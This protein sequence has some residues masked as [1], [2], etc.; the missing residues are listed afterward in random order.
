ML[1]SKQKTIF[2]FI[3]QGQM[4]KL[5]GDSKK[6]WT[7]CK[8]KLIRHQLLICNSKWNILL[9][10]FYSPSVWVFRLIQRTR[11]Q[12]SNIKLWSLLNEGRYPDF[13][14]FVVY[15]AF[16]IS[17]FPQDC[18]TWWV[19]NSYSTIP[20]FCQYFPNLKIN[21]KSVCIHVEV[22]CIC[23]VDAFYE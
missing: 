21:F 2:T 23:I 11:L 17:I 4:I 9:K 15:L 5:N 22:S 7:F 12:Q 6:I 10:I 19:R 3:R 20:L 8:K 18:S 13:V 14:L 16:V 1:E